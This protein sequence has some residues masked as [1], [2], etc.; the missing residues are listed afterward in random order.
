M[1]GVVSQVFVNESIGGWVQEHN[2]SHVLYDKTTH[3]H[4]WI[5]AHQLNVLPSINIDIH[6][7]G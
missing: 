6:A 1:F 5:K 2:V 7:D 3:S 4:I